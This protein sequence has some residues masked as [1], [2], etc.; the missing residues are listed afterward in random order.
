MKNWDYSD[1]AKEA[2]VLGGPDGLREHYTDVGKGEG[3]IETAIV[4]GIILIVGGGLAWGINKIRNHVKQKKIESQVDKI[5]VSE[6]RAIQSN[7]DEDED[8][9]GE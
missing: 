8:K 7:G 4:G 5:T 9:N 2:K 6:L 3:R 1:L